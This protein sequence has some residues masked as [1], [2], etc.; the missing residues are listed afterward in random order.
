VLHCSALCTKASV[1]LWDL[2]TDATC[3][4][5]GPRAGILFLDCRLKHRYHVLGIV[6][7]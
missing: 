5:L 1:D 2:D 4:A 6:L 3:F 7:S